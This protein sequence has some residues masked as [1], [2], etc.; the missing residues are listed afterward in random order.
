MKSRNIAMAIVAIIL[1]VCVMGSHADT[2]YFGGWSTHLGEPDAPYNQS[3]EMLGYERGNVFA[4]RFINSH[5]RE[6]YAVAY[7]WKWQKADIQWGIYAGAVYGYRSCY[8]DDG[9]KTVYC[10]LLV[11]M[12]SYTKY[13]VQPTVLLM[14]NA[15]T[16]AIRYSF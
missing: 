12:V 14:G 3:H 5:N 10:P 4:A 15:A 8:G 13:A 16:F 2:L 9:E 1:L 6:S 7:A 11:P